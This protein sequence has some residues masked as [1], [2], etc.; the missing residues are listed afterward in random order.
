LIHLPHG[1]EGTNWITPGNQGQQEIN[2]IHGGDVTATNN[3]ASGSVVMRKLCKRVLALIKHKV[4][5]DGSVS[6]HMAQALASWLQLRGITIYTETE[7]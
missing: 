5:A 6:E 7:L 2:G 4:G 3:T 1:L